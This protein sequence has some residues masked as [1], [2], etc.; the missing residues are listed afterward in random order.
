MDSST[1][2][3]P[4]WSLRTIEPA[5]DRQHTHTA[6]LLHGRDNNCH[7]FASEF[8]E[9]EISTVPRP[10]TFQTLFPS[11]KWV[12]PGAF[13]IPSD[14]FSTPLT[15]WFD[16]WSVE[17]PGERPKIQEAGLRQSVSFIRKVIADES[18]LVPRNCVYIGGISQGFVTAV[19]AYLADVQR[20]GGLLGFL[21]RAYPALAIYGGSDREPLSTSMSDYVGE[22]E[23]TPRPHRPRNRRPD[24]SST[25]RPS[26]A[27][28]FVQHGQSER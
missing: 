21:S 15:Q 17:N 14:R 25:E 26:F 7:D 18:R 1:G 8:F 11:F 27:R 28:C 9:S 12:F 20:L 22:I 10:R 2:E 13:P 19:A 4:P 24:C 16:I 5:N 6:V 23:A 3:R